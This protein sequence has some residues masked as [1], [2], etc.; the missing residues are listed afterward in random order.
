MDNPSHHEMQRDTPG[1]FG[2]KDISLHPVHSHPSPKRNEMFFILL[3]RDGVVDVQIDEQRILA[4]RNNVIF[5]LPA[6]YTALRASSSSK[7]KAIWFSEDFMYDEHNS[8]NLLFTYHL[9]LPTRNSSIYSLSEHSAN[10]FLQIVNAMELEQGKKQ[11]VF[12]RKAQYLLLHILLLSL[13]RTLQASPHHTHTTA[14]IFETFYSL[15]EKNYKILDSVKLYAQKIGVSV[16]KLKETTQNVA[17]TSPLNV[18]HNRRLI[19]AKR[20]LVFTSMK[21]KDIAVSL[22]H[23]DVANFCRFFHHATGISPIQYRKQHSEVKTL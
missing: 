7:I 4:R 3:I 21:I 18:I 23:N 19:E 15:V 13:S 8:E 20:Q 9:F 2:I 11:E 6:Q 22:G 1:P 5:L 17:H 14:A 12:H 16:R 10:E